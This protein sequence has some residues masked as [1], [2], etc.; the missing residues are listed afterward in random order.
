M[1]LCAGYVA[2]DGAEEL[3]MRFYK[4]VAPDEA[5]ERDHQVASAG[6]TESGDDFNSD[7]EAASTLRSIAMEDG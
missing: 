2:P 5:T 4:D 7:G 3:R 1:I 6:E